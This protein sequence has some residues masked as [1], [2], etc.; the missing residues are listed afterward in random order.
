[1]GC[2]VGDVYH[3]RAMSEAG[4]GFS[5]TIS[6]VLC[7][8]AE[9]DLR[10]FPARSPEQCRG[11]E[12]LVVL[13]PG[14]RDR[15]SEGAGNPAAFTWCLRVDPQIAEAYGSSTWLLAEYEWAWSQFRDAGDAVGVHPHTWRWRNGWVADNADAEWVAHC[16]DVAIEGYREA[17][18]EAPQVHKQ[19]DGFMTTALARRLDAHGVLVDLSLEPG[20]RPTRAL[21]AGEE[22]T[23]WLPDLRSVPQSAYRPALDD[24]RAPD[25]ARRTGLVMLP[26]TAGL[27][28]A[29]TEVRA[30]VVGAGEY[31]P[32]WLWRE[33][34]QFRAMLQVRLSAPD[35]THLAF[36]VRSDT[37]L[38]DGLWT[39]VETNLA[40]IGRQLKGRH[41]WCCAQSAATT[42]IERSHVQ[43]ARARETPTSH[44]ANVGYWLRG[45]ADPGY[46]E[47][48]DLGALAFGPGH[49]LS[50]EQPD[51]APLD[52]SA[53]L[54]VYQG[55]R[56]LRH[57][58]DSVVDQ[59]TPPAELIVVDDGSTDDDLDFLNG[60]A[61]PFPIRIARQANA[62]QSAARNAGVQLA[63]GDLVAFLDQDDIWLPEHLKTLCGPF[64]TDPAVAWSYGEFDEIDSDGRVV[65]RSYLRQN[66]VAHPKNSL[67][68]CL[69]HDLMVPPSASV[70]RRDAFIEVGGFDERL[71]GF[72]DDDLYVRAF[73]S[74]WEFSFQRT[75]VTRFRVHQESD[76]DGPNFVASR[77]RYAEKLQDTVR[78]DRRTGRYYLSDVVSPRFFHASLDDYVRH[79]SS[80]DWAS[81]HRSLRDL[82]Y[83]GRLRRDWPALRWKV[84]LISS[85]RLFA[86]M[87]AVHD[88]LPK[89]LRMTENPAIRRR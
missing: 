6:V 16:S 61:A 1:V 13:V 3:P 77:R 34:D 85:P 83:F 22:T 14:L 68:E 50:G 73:R 37:T 12:R 19:G 76:S 53:I 70:I 29:L 25:D 65:T 46:R 56:H 58:V 10:V 64:E 84:S 48:V 80:G 31:V 67:A 57:A 89:W 4:E 28:L 72:E 27:T 35:L 45:S 88:A 66:A 81:A 71:R 11:L 17:F 30:R 23:G 9:P 59:T 55:R 44:D 47:D 42:A 33:P 60:L 62:G 18:D 79:V 15:L 69:A 87:L 38:N 74:G 32:L 2:T 54:P 43:R 52:V 26:L 24:F 78:D 41:R 82:R 51:T 40:E 86:H 39:N 7:I 5:E 63:T 20:R 49:P 36:A 75:P 21:A 8:D